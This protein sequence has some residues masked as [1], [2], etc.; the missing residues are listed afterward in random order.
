M[1][2]ISLTQPEQLR[3]LLAQR[4]ELN[5]AD[6]VERYLGVLREALFSNRAEVRPSALK[7][8]AAEE[9][10]ALLHFLRKTGFSAAERGE[11]LHRAGFNAGAI[12]KLSQASRQFLLNHLENHQIAPMLEI[13]DAYQGAIIEGFVQSIDKTNLSDLEQLRSIMQRDNNS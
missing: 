3:V 1:E 10:E 12:L 8:I 9:A 7:S 6:L 11:K 13:V 4:V 2:N 5:R